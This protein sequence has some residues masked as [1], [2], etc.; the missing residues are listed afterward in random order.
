MMGLSLMHM[1]G[2]SSSVHFTHAEYNW[3][4]FLLHYI[5]VLCQ[6]RLYRADYAYL[7]YF[8]LQRH[9]SHL[10]GPKLNH[11]QVQASSIFSVWLCLILYIEHVHSH[12]FVWL[13]LVSYT[14]LLHNR[15]HTEGWKLCA[16]RGPMC[17]L[18]NFQWCAEPCF[19]DAAVLWSRYLPLIPRRDKSK[20]LYD[21][22]FK[23]NQ[24]IL[25][26]SLLRLTTRVSF[27]NSALPVIVLM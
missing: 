22:R 7:T 5:Q 26:S 15:I 6:S 23:A 2:L 21:G 14:I 19:E 24:F 20:L 13:Q 8:M 1:L 17:T 25:A 11:R 9:L 16:N 18:E 27:F 4:N 12:D 3:K 10:N